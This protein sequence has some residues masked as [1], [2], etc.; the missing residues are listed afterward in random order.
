METVIPSEVFE[1]RNSSS[2]PAIS[3]TP[4]SAAEKYEDFR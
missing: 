4:Q 2:Y 3:L 1:A